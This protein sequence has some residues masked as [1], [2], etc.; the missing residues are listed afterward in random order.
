MNK[1]SCVI[2]VASMR[3]L[4]GVGMQLGKQT[5]TS[6]EVEYMPLSVH[7]EVRLDS[8]I[9]LCQDEPSRGTVAEQKTVSSSAPEVS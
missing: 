5:G 8:D 2:Q 3:T 9:F 1:V 7:H 4:L 6:T